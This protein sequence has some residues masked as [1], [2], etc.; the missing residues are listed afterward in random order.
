MSGRRR[1]LA[2]VLLVLGLAVGGF[3]VS[4]AHVNDAGAELP[5]IVLAGGL[6]LAALAGALEV[7][8]G[9]RAKARAEVD[10]LFTMSPDLIV[11]VGFDGYFKRVNPAFETRLGYTEQEALTR[12]YLEFVHPDDRKRTNAKRQELHEG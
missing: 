5:W 3:F 2:P 11:L 6:V 8:S 10:R 7:N 9:R 1:Q 12:P 4:R